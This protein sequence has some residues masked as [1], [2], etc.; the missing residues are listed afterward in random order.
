MADNQAT[1]QGTT[2][3]ASL[4]IALED[5]PAPDW[6]Q[7]L[8]RSADATFCHWREWDSV[9]ED[10]M[11][12]QCL[13]LHAR[14]EAGQLRGG[15]PLARVRS[16][17]FGDYLVS[18]PY[19]NYGGPIGEPEAQAALVERAAEYARQLRVDS[20]ELRARHQVRT[21]IPVAQRR[22]TVILPLPES[23]DAL[24]NDGFRSKLR[25]QI[26]R[27]VKEGMQFRAGADQVRP[28]FEVFA[29]NMRDLGTPSLP[30]AWFEKISAG[31]GDGVLFGV[32]YVGE[33]PVAGGCG[34]FGFGEFEM[35]WASSLREWD[36]K[37]PN[38]LLYWS[39]MQEAISRGARAFNFGR[40][41]EGGGTHRF[42][43]QWGG[44]DVPLPWIRWAPDAD[45]APPGAGDSRFAL[46][47]A[48]WKR[49]PLTITRGVG[50]W[51]AR[52]I[53]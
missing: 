5:V 10:V 51:L 21:T 18:M 38:M 22:I 24:W 53:P 9:L 2:L 31:F 40:C 32:V 49:L 41:V 44:D 27:P 48:A 8:A 4:S 15:L 1:L 14:D 13:W 52:K 6:Q 45:A 39:F 37:S 47:S 34:F 23:S 26:R 7:L 46:A 36:A 19:L 29:R 50:P 33:Q 42:K 28:F 25:S 3:G 16:R 17:I 12:A 11:G 35:T 20:L 43:K 30:L